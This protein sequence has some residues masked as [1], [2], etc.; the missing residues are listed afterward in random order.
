MPGPYEVP[1]EVPLLY[2]CIM[3]SLALYGIPYEVPLLYEGIMKYPYKASSRISCG[4]QSP[5]CHL[6]VRFCLFVDTTGLLLQ[7]PLEFLRGEHIACV[8]LADYSRTFY[9]CYATCAS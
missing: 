9:L 8:Q 4:L 5:I 6:L 2:E 3:K 1:Y 7:G